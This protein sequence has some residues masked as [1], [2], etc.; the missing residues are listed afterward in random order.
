MSDKE[1]LDDILRTTW[2]I[3]PRFSDVDHQTLNV[4]DEATALC[5]VFTEGK[6]GGENTPVGIAYDMPV[7][8]A[9]HIVALHNEHLSQSAAKMGER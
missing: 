2:R 9:N 5:T 8:L 4:I 7:M 6:W 1:I 3:A